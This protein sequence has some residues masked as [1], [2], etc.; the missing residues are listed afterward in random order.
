[1]ALETFITYLAKVEQRYEDL[2]KAQRWVM[3]F[4]VP[5]VDWDTDPYFA[6]KTGLPI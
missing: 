1:M 4:V 3:V 6:V 2:E 5:R